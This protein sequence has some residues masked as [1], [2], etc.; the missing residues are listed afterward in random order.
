M[1][2]QQVST[3]TVLI[4]SAIGALSVRQTVLMGYDIDDLV[5]DQTR[6]LAIQLQIKNK[7][8]TVN[9]TLAA[10]RPPISIEGSTAGGY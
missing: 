9:P 3:S 4:D 2:T 5:H 8:G 1:A 6:A 10:N 7:V